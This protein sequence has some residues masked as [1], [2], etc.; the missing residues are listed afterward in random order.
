MTHADFRPKKRSGVVPSG[1]PRRKI[2]VLR[3]LLLIAIAF[4]VYLKFDSIWSGVRALN[5]VA[6]WDRTFGGAQPVAD[7]LPRPAWSSDSSEFSLDCPRGLPGCCETAPASAKGGNGI[8]RQAGALL[9]KARARGALGGLPA[10]APLRLYAKAGVTRSGHGFFHLSALQGR[11]PRGKTAGAAFAFRRN[12]AGVWCDTRHVCLSEPAPRPPLSL[13]RLLRSEA[14]PD[15]ARW[16][17]A[18]AAVHPALAGRITT[19]DS[20]NGGA[21][22][23]IYHGGELY[24]TYEP[25]RLQDTAVRAGAAVTPRSVLGESPW[26]AA[27]YTVLVRARRAGLN[28]DPADFFSVQPMVE[29]ESTDSTVAVPT[30][31]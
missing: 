9:T 17:S 1:K 20:V 7:N 3:I 15:A 30:D 13:G 19:V 23:R 24:T 11:V 27:G 2:P 6:L 18:S 10:D 22:V 12:S 28:L 4:F 29:A 21:R 14:S 26:L 31:P 25:L 16:V 5:P 8:C